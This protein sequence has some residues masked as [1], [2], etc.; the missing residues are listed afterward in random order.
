MGTPTMAYGK[1][2]G[3]ELPLLTETRPPRPSTRPSAIAANPTQVARCRPA[4]LTLPLGL[5]MRQPF[6]ACVRTS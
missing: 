5:Q 6:G 2:A 4:E 3:V 1:A